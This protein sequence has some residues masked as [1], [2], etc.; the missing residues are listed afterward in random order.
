MKNEL[1]IKSVIMTM[2]VCFS[3]ST[4]L[5][6]MHKRKEHVIAEKSKIVNE[7]YNN[8]QNKY[9]HE[10]EDNSHPINPEMRISSISEDTLLIKDISSENPKLI[11]YFS[12][13]TCK[14][15]I[16]TELLR[17]KEKVKN[18]GAENIVLLAAYENVRSLF[19]LCKEN[20]VNYPSFIIHE[21]SF[22]LN[23]DQQQLPYYFILTDEL[24]M[25]DFFIVDQN[26]PEITDVYL[27]IVFSKYFL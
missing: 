6:K 7:K 22:D 13:L 8:L 23:A 2:V 11:F 9:F 19:L 5:Y 14:S 15:C 1:V 16:E 4:V 12:G 10:I 18:I 20:G 27:D 24:W 17:L 3:V 26:A 25:K 21:N